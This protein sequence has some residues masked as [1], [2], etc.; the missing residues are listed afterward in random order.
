MSK[1]NYNK[2][3]GLVGVLA[4]V[5]LVAVIGLVGWRFYASQTNQ[6]ES[7]KSSTKDAS[8]LESS[9]EVPPIENIGDLDNALQALDN[10]NVDDG[11][12]TESTQLDSE[13]QAF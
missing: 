4:I 11:K 5:V 2:G 7:S 13:A 8:T 6:P 9:Q 12:D 3:F 10:T 1:N